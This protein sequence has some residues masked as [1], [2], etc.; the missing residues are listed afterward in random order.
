GATAALGAP[1]RLRPVLRRAPAAAC[2]YR[3]AL[4]LR[5]HARGSWELRRSALVGALS[6]CCVR[7]ELA[8]EYPVPCEAAQHLLTGG[9]AEGVPIAAIQELD[10]IGH[11][12]GV[13][14]GEDA[15]AIVD[16]LGE[17]AATCGDD[18]PRA[19]HRLEDHE[20]ERLA[21]PG[22]HECVARGDPLRKLA[23]VGPVRQ[24]RDVRGE[25]R[26][27]VSADEQQMIRT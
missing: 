1:R 15:D 16:Q 17:G 26:A 20:S 7:R 10:R 3:K 24:N 4:V 18:G 8:L 5:A 13:R 19:S 14:L 12:A 6:E 2:A 11:S 9:G 21:R 23:A 22:V 27:G 25:A